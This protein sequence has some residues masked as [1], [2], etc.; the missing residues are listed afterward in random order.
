MVNKIIK[1]TLTKCRL[2][3]FHLLTLG[4]EGWSRRTVALIWQQVSWLSSPPYGE[5]VYT[6]FMSYMARDNILINIH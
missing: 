3:H 6:L 5:M 1:K 2:R 4:R